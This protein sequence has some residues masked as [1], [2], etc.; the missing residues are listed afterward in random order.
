MAKHVTPKDEFPNKV[1]P[2]NMK[3]GSNYVV[4]FHMNGCPACVS[5]MPTWKQLYETVYNDNRL[6]VDLIHVEMQDIQ[7]IAG[8]KVLLTGPANAIA[9]FPTIL[10]YSAKTQQFEEHRDSRDYATMHSILK[11][12]YMV[13]PK[14]IKAP[15]KKVASPAK[16]VASPP[17]KK[18][19]ASPAKK[20]PAKKAQK[21]GDCGCNAPLPLLPGALPMA[22]GKSKSKKVVRRAQSGGFVRGGITLPES[23]YSRS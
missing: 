7:T 2:T 9:Y 13:A 11:E 21:G 16:K 14:A 6:N 17:A 10:F 3:K 12:R 22:G 20:S 23:F 15:A 8:K 18:A 5:F 4:L 19:A 1:S